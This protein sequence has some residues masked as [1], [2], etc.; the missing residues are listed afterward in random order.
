MRCAA[1]AIAFRP[2]EQKRLTV[3]PD[4][5]TGQPARL[6]MIRAMLLPVAP[7]GSAQPIT[8]SST[9]DGSTF[10][11]SSAALTT[12]PPSVAPWL[13]LKAPRQLFASGVRAVETITASRSRAL[14]RHLP[15]SD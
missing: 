7:S 15:P 1:I 13:M 8:T 3:S 12:C 6:A 9:A 10:A 4:T 5:L 14:M 11:R 2:E